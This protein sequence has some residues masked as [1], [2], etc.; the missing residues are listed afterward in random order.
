M[1]QKEELRTIHGRLWS[2]EKR[3][4]GLGASL[5]H[6]TEDSCFT[7]DELLGLGFFL[8]DFAK[9]ISGINETLT[10]IICFP[11]REQNESK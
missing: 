11:E 5:E 2:I 8:K 1:T 3:L 9:E 7:P 4:K 6:I 10:T